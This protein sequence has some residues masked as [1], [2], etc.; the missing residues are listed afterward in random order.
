MSDY[1]EPRE[2]GFISCGPGAGLK[3][4]AYDYIGLSGEKYEK[5]IATVDIR[6]KKI[7]L[8]EPDLEHD[9]SLY[10]TAVT[11]DGIDGYVLILAH[12]RSDRLHG[13]SIANIRAFVQLIVMPSGVWAPGVPIVL[14]ACRSGQ[15]P[16]GIASALAK[17]LETYVTAPS[18]SS[19]TYPY[20]WPFSKLKDMRIGDGVYPPLIETPAPYKNLNFS[21]SNIEKLVNVSNKAVHYLKEQ[22]SAIPNRL[23]PG[24]W[25]TWGPDGVLIAAT[26]QPLK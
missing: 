18:D 25:R 19:W 22:I 21:N 12:A 26:E 7:I 24:E 11:A 4:I 17:T 16:A 5:R 14:D 6:R 10:Q 23:K 13:F 20:I 1:Q 2:S 8:L 3:K 9:K 15:D